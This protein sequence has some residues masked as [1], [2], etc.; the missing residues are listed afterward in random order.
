MVNNTAC[1]TTPPERIETAS[2]LNKKTVLLFLFTVSL[3]LLPRNSA[4]ADP[5]RKEN[6]TS[7]LPTIR[8]GGYIIYMRHGEA[9]VGQ[10]SPDVNLND[11]GTQRNLSE[12]GKKQAE[13]LGQI[14]ST[15]HIPVSYPVLASSFCRTQ[16]TAKIAFGSNNVQVYPLLANIEELRKTNVSNERKQSI[17]EDLTKMLETIPPRG[18]NQILVGHMFPAGTLLGE[19]PNMGTVIIKPRGAGK[20]YEIVKRISLEQWSTENNGYLQRLKKIS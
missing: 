20:G 18:A 6:V 16:E 10:D 19:I 1:L 17:T 8:N 3:V 15:L 5:P 9:T 11:C 12:E 7:F 14:F 13:S 2:M 4:E